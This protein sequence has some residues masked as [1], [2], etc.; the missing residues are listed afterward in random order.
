M[1]MKTF[2]A[3]V[4]SLSLSVAVAVAVISPANAQEV[5]DSINGQAG[6]PLTPGVSIEQPAPPRGNVDELKS[7]AQRPR[8]ALTLAGGGGRGG[9]HIGVLKVL[10]ENGIKPDFVAGSSIGA[11]IGALYCS[12]RTP[13]EIEQLALD[14]KFRKGLLPSGIKWQMIK[15]A[16]IYGLKRLLGMKPPV[17]LY[18]GKT[19]SK[20]IEKNLA[21]GVVRMEDLKI[22]MAVVA[23]NLLDTRP[24]W[25]SKGKIADAVTA[26]AAIPYIYRPVELDHA[27]LVDGGLRDNVPTGLAEASGTPFV[28]AVKLHSKLPAMSKK[29]L[30][31]YLHFSDRILTI[32]MAEFEHKSTPPADIVIAPD[33]GTANTAELSDES[34]A[35]T[36]KAGEDEAR[37]MMPEICR[38]LARYNATAEST[39]TLHQ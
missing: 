34:F 39:P 22:P 25:I 36:I 35:Q 8:I 10:E 30:R 19:M 9:A 37:K 33:L 28:I 21:P 5:G 18:S 16:P 17:G 3:Y 2:R 7:Q 12:G 1:D 4:V 31:N 15:T 24:V 6:T 27:V 14:G 26:S 38:R 29:D 20:F 13:Q 32:T 23:T 11:I